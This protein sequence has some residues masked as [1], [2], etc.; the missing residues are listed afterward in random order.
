[1]LMLHLLH[2]LNIMRKLTL[3]LP[4]VFFGTMALAQKSTDKDTA[5]T[6]T[7]SVVNEIKDDI[8]ETIP[9]VTIDDEGD[10]GGQGVAS[11]LTAGRDPFYNAAS[12]NFNAVRFRIRGYDN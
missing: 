12:F 9:T 2:Q 5:R 6:K 4:A 7:D 10:G 11:L 3:L 8:T 1:M